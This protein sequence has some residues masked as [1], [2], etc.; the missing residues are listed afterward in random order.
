[1]SARATCTAAH[2]ATAAPGAG[3]GLFICRELVSI[4]GGRMWARS[5]PEGGAEFGFSLPAYVDETEPAFDL[6]QPTIRPE[7][8]PTHAA[9]EAQPAGV[10]TAQPGT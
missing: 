8:A 2:H 6:P 10:G 4:M 9:S 3:I 5:R 1:V 7:P